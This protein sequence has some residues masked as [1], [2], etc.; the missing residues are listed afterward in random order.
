MMDTFELRERARD[1]WDIHSTER[2][3]EIVAEFVC[4]ACERMIDTRT[5]RP[6]TFAMW[7]EGTTKNF[8]FN[9]SCCRNENTWKLWYHSSDKRHRSYAIIRCSFEFNLSFE[10]LNRQV[11]YSISMR[12]R[13]L[14]L[15]LTHNEISMCTMH[16]YSMGSHSDS[17]FA[18]SSTTRHSRILLC[19]ISLSISTATTLAR[20]VADLFVQMG[21]FHDLDVTHTQRVKTVADAMPSHNVVHVLLFA[22]VSG[23]YLLTTR[24]T[25]FDIHIRTSLQHYPLFTLFIVIRWICGVRSLHNTTH[26]WVAVQPDPPPKRRIAITRRDFVC[27]INLRCGD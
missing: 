13:R 4:Y 17:F 27:I 20:K 15:W 12:L 1:R 7:I 21:S 6:E 9:S 11:V 14:W 25:L 5:G 26:A 19:R 3:S 18:T 2:I 8:N 22:K 23:V 10:F 16:V 24:R